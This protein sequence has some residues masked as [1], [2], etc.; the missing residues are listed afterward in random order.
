MT[1]GKLYL[2]PNT[3]DFGIEGGAV[4][5]NEVLPMHVIQ[6]AARLNYWAAE[7]AKTTRH[8]L[9]RVDAV[10]P[11]ATPLQSLNIAE[12][13]RPPKGRSDGRGTD[14]VNQ[15]AAWLALLTPALAGHDI[16]LMSEAGLPAIAD[17]GALLVVHHRKGRVIATEVHQ[18]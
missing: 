15:N 7:S 1:P 13:P 4:D 8:F 17:P 11:L 18:P 6:T 10:V 14:H 9:K 3:L 12:L 2:V 5:L 16:G